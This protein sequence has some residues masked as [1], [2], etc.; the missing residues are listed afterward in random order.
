VRRLRGRAR[1]DEHGA[2]LI[3]VIGFLVFIGSFGAAV[4]SSVTS[5]FNDRTVLD[6]VRNR[7]YAA[8]GGIE[9]A[10]AR[11]R[12]LS[13]AGGP[14]LQPC[15]DPATPGRYYLPT[16]MNNF[17]IRIDCDISPTRLIAGSYLQRNV[18]FTACVKAT[19][20]DVAC[21]DQAKTPVVIR[22]QVNFE[23]PPLSAV[24]TRTY[25]QSWSVDG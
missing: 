19:P 17:L 9:Y 6:Q 22:A 14:G 20:V 4:L 16:T 11:V 25:I 23:T 21:G 5:G 2:S 8:D 7:Q 13:N 10:I 15:G 12:A 3:L 18:V 24:T 1:R